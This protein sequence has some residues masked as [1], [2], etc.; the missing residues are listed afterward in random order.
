MKAYAVLDG[1]G[2]KGAALAGCLKGAQAFGIE[3]AGYGGT[4][5]GSIVALLASIG[6]SP[7]E[8]R[9]VMCRD[10][11]F[12]EFLDDGGS[13]LTQWGATA[14]ELLDAKSTSRRFFEGGKIWWR[15]G[16]ALKARL[17]GL[18]IYGGT[19]LEA[20]L[21]DL[22]TRKLHGLEGKPEIT[23]ADLRREGGLPLRVVAAH[24]RTRQA[25]VFSDEADSPTNNV[26]TAVRA[27][28]CYP[29][30]FK[31][32]MLGRS[33]FVDGGLASNLPVWLFDAE[34]ARSGL[35]VVAFDLT[36]KL[37]DDA[38]QAAYHPGEYVKDM[39]ETALEAGD[40]LLRGATERLIHVRVALDPSFRT[41]D[42]GMSSTLREDLYDKGRLA[43]LVEFTS[44]FVTQDVVSDRLAQI[45]SAYG[46]SAFFETALAGLAREMEAAFPQSGAVRCSVFLPFGNGDLWAAYTHGMA[47]APDGDL[48]LGAT[49]GP[50]GIAI[51]NVS[52]I[53]SDWAV[54]RADP[55]KFEMN[56][57]QV[58][59]VP[60]DRRAVASVPVFDAR[61]PV[62]ID[63]EALA[64]LR[65]RGALCVDCAMEA[66]AAGWSPEPGEYDSDLVDIL[67]RWA[68]VIGRILT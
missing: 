10:L 14:K 68:D 39:I 7:D 44:R 28:C 37:S 4:S 67:K 45:E 27:S 25:V 22:V 1:G 60:P 61:R 12:S 63:H 46:S 9:T 62:H 54:I 17:N 23:F 5:A 65:T 30:L 41:L 35:Q 24:L 8:L 48:S 15:H 56:Q 51:E 38:E 49:A 40:A 31:P 52:P 29:V 50:P 18:G 2:V 55:G 34:R 33:P 66:D 42:F 21:K 16:D 59:K 64:G 19:K 13:E 6:Y 3:F 47:N 26:I 57:F 53:L 36:T 11:N 58:N 32:V 43:A 20:K